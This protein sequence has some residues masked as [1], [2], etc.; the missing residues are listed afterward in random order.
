MLRGVIGDV[1]ALFEGRRS[2]WQIALWFAEPNDLLACRP[3]ALLDDDPGAV[4][5]AARLDFGADARDH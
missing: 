3:L 4:L 2:K 5:Y 1:L